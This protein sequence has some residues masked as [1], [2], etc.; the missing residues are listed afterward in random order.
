MSML[1]SKENS[2]EIAFRQPLFFFTVIKNLKFG[3]FIKVQNV[4]IGFNQLV[5][6]H[7]N[8]IS[9]IIYIAIMQIGTNQAKIGF[10]Q[11]LIFMPSPSF[12]SAIRFCQPNPN[13]LEQQNSE[14]IKAP[15]G[16]RLL[17]TIKS[18]KSS[19]AEPS[20]NGWNLN[21]L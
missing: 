10:I 5:Y 20:P 3:L 12:A 14:N 9:P 15:S 11:F 6:F 8:V 17:L 4:F 2:H 21:T 19:H 13:L 1:I 7:L 18:Q 16:R